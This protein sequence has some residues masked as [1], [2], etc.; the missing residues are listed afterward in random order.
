MR[1]PF[2]ISGPVQAL[3]AMSYRLH[4]AVQPDHRVGVQ[5]GL[6]RLEVRASFQSPEA[7]P[8][9]RVEEQDARAPVVIELPSAGEQGFERAAGYAALLHARPGMFREDCG[10]HHPAFPGVPIG[11][12]IETAG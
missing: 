6:D 7:L 1:R 8:R 12:S 2:S 10:N 11:N 5:P 3:V 4:A 9:R